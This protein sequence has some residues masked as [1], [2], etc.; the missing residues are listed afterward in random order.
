M[1]KSI[2][3]KEFKELLKKGIVTFQYYKKDG[4]Y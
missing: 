4:L 3:I 2:T 1:I